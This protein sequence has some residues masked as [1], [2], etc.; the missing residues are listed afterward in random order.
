MSK[1]YFTDLSSGSKEDNLPHR[2]ETLFRKAG[3]G[4]E[5]EE[6]DIVSLK[7]HFGEKG[8]DT[9]IRPVQVNPI[10]KAVKNA[11]GKPFL[12]DSNTLY[13]GSRSNAVDHHMTAQ[14]N[15]WVRPVVEA[16]VVI[17][18]GL[19]GNEFY[20]VEVNG[21]HFD[22]VKIGAAFYQADGIIGVSHFKGHMMTGFGGTLKNLGMGCASR[23]GKLMMHYDVKP[24]VDLEKCIGCG[25]CKIWCPA[26]AIE[27][28]DK[29]EIDLGECIGCGECKIVCPEG[30]IK[31]E[32]SSS[33]VELQ[34]K[35]SEFA[36][37]S[38]LGKYDKSMFFNFVMDVTPECDCP[39]WRS[40]PMVPDIGIVASKDP[41]AVEQAAFDLVKDEKGRDYDSG[42]DK[43]REE[44][45]VDPTA[46]I[47]HAEKIGMG[48]REYELIDISE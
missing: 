24:E 33:N 20:E 1:V 27:V 45:D 4:L 14:E 47:V 11:G 26:D 13:T 12:G 36:H 46:Q 28:D 2:I 41:V 43:F 9:F 7:L 17:A 30:A 44:H 31:V 42:V 18:D 48:E 40:Y 34:E 19:H 22:D 37:G 10:I 25:R 32:D 39:P 5:Y 3:D 35:I 29:A 23:A 15:G 21:K 16:P 8:I 38:L 6:D